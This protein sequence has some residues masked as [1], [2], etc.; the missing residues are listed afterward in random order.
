MQTTVSTVRKMLI[1]H[2]QASFDMMTPCGF[3]FLTP[4]TTKEL[5]A[6]KST[7]GNPGTSGYDMEIA[8]DEL[9]NQIVINANYSNNTWHLLSDS[10]IKKCED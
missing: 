5:L 8:A 10:A 9:L 3:V 2:P 7:T 6:G 4:E 1:E